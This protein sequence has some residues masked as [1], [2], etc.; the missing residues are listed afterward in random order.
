M[1]YEELWPSTFDSGKYFQLNPSPLSHRHWWTLEIV[2]QVEVNGLLNGSWWSDKLGLAIPAL[3][4]MELGRG[5]ALMKLPLYQE[6]KAC[7]FSH[8]LHPVPAKQ[9]DDDIRLWW[10]AFLQS[11]PSTGGLASRKTLRWLD[12]EDSTFL[13]TRGNEGHH[14]KK[15]TNKD[16]GVCKA[17]L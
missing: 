12:T 15:H 6:T 4:G 10:D 7:S 5:N 11:T 2:H 17:P 8:G 16:N 9:A 1:G 14:H 3:L 13:P